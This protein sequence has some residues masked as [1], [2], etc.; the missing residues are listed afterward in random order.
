MCPLYTFTRGYDVF[1]I[2]VLI[3]FTF[4]DKPE[5]A[6]LTTNASQNTVTEGD[7][8]T[9]KCIVMAAVPQVSIYKFYFNRRLVRGN[10]NSEYTLKNVNRSQ[11]FGEYKCVP[12]NNAG[13][14]A[15]ATV[16]LN[17]NGG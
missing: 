15:E 1:K 13:D 12:H 5:G 14:G 6:R 11:H 17:I 8:V 9:F 7:T 10:S 4:S 2:K 16:R 3:S